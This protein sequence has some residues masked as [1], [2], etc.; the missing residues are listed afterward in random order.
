MIFNHPKNPHAIGTVLLTVLDNMINDNKKNVGLTIEQYRQI[1]KMKIGISVKMCGICRN[2]YVKDELIN[3]LP[4][5]HIFHI[6]C[7]QDWLKIN[8][9][10]PWMS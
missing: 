8:D 1:K 6:D 10:C 3:R 5:K 9:T 4:C 7:L 2:N